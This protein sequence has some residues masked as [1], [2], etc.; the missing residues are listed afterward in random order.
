M[1]YFKENE[2]VRLKAF[3]HEFLEHEF[4][5]NDDMEQYFNKTVTVAHYDDDSF[6]INEDGGEWMYALEWIVDPVTLPEELFTL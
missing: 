6:H 2:K 4:G 1:R 5:C 3:R